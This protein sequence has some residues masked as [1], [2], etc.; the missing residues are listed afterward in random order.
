MSTVIMPTGTQFGDDITRVAEQLLTT[1]VKVAAVRTDFI[2]L[3]AAELSGKTLSNLQIA[4][5]YRAAVRKMGTTHPKVVLQLASRILPGVMEQQND[6]D[7]V[8]G[9]LNRD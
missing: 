6:I 5:A 7:A 9:M 8:H 4:D 1:D 3:L 2:P